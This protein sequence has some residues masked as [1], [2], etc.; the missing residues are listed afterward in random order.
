MF[1]KGGIRDR[2]P[3]QKR[4]LQL[5]LLPVLFQRKMQTAVVLLLSGQSPHGVPLPR[6]HERNHKTQKGET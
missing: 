4:R 6:K 3:I 5:P 2:L 1:T